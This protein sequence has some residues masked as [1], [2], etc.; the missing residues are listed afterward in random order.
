MFFSIIIKN[1]NWKVLNKNLVTFSDG[2]GYLRMNNFDISEGSLKH[3]IFFW[4]GGG[5]VG[6][7]KKPISRG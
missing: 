2:M 4:G 6:V 3:Q 5:E 7:T 1:S